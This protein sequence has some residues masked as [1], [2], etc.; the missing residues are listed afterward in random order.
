M[1]LVARVSL[2]IGCGSDG[3]TRPALS[4]A[5]RQR[6]G[7][8]TWCSASPN[9][10]AGMPIVSAQERPRRQGAGARGGSFVSGQVRVRY[11]GAF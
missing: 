4:G 11:L 9:S 8:L 1:T 3:E 7:P 2:L 6:E 5:Q 10:R